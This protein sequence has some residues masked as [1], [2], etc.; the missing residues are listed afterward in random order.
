MKHHASSRARRWLVS[1]AAVLVVAYLVPYKVAAGNTLFFLRGYSANY[2]LARGAVL[3]SRVIDTTAVIREKVFPPG[4][5]HV[6]R[7]AAALDDLKLLR[8]LLVR[9]N[10][11]SALPHESADG[12]RVAGACEAVAITG[13]SYRASGWALLKA[14]GRPPDCVVIAYQTPDAEPILFA[15]SDSIETRWDIARHSWPND[16]LWSG[17]T[18][19]FPASRVPPGAKLSFWAVDA[20]EPKLYRLD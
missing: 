7:N 11:L 17:W 15:I 1:V 9:S 18:A 19:T 6:V 3:F 2:R 14:K 13:E 8:P 12:K 10:R 4:P 16:Y 20:D 5:D